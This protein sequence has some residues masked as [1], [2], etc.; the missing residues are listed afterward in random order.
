MPEVN[1]FNMSTHTPMKLSCLFISALFLHCSMAGFISIFSPTPS[2]AQNL[3]Q[4]PTKPFLGSVNLSTKTAVLSVGRK[5][6]PFPDYKEARLRYPIA[7]GLKDAAVLQKVQN[8]ISLKQV[9]GKSLAEMQQEYPINH[10]LTE[11]IYTVNYNRN[12]ILDL[13]YQVSGAGAYSDTY[14]KYVSVN[15][16]TGQKLRA[17]DLFKPSA[18]GTIAQ[19]VD[20]LMQREIQKKRE[21]AG[22]RAPEFRTEFF[23]NHQFQSKH[24]DTFSIS[25]KGITFHYD[26]GFPHVAKAVEPSGT[27]LLSYAQLAPHLKVEGILGFMRR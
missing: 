11:V 27:Y 16:K 25:E 1:T 22:W 14:E 7:S 3:S 23:E 8:A 13:T 21:E 10:W 18:M 6:A 4:S 5:G 2:I 26:F 15:L 17:K 12:G 9:L 24:L 19:S 20:K